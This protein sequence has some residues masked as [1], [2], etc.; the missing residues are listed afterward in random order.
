MMPVRV[1]NVVLAVPTEQGNWTKTT[2]MLV[3]SSGF[4]EE[5]KGI[6]GQICSAIEKNAVV[7]MTAEIEK[8]V[9]TK[10]AKDR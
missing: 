2:S 1:Q 6:V 4:L 9:T 3:Y 10:K 7:V 8:V 5:K